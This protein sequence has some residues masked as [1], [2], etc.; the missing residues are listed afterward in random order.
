MNIYLQDFIKNFF[1]GGTIIGIYTI[2]TKYISPGYAIHLAS[3]LPIV[4]TY[5]AVI[6]YRNYSINKTI[7]ILYLAFFAGLI[8]QLYVLIFYI[9]LKSNLNIVVSIVLCIIIYIIFSYLLYRYLKK[10]Y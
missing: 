1:I 5:I 9:E 3:S 2:I 10:Y 6:T 8:W 4:V 7:N